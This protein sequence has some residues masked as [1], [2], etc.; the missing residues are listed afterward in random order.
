MEGKSMLRTF[1]A[2]TARSMVTS[3]ALHALVLAV[4]MLVPA[5]GLL[6]SAP[7][8]KNVELDIVFYRPPEVAVRPRA[9]ALPLPKA[10]ADAGSPAGAPA[11]AAKPKANA[12]P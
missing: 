12:A 4:L 10:T 7:P 5:A 8:K 2:P 6:R 1:G 3:I 9:I 11:R